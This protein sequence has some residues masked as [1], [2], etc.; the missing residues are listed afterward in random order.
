MKINRKNITCNDLY[1]WVEEGQ[2][3]L[4]DFEEALK[5]ID[6]ASDVE[7]DGI[8]FQL[9]IADEFYVSTHPNIQHYKKIQYSD[10][11]LK[12][13]I[14]YTHER[15]LD[16]IATVL[17][18][19]LIP[20]LIDFGCNAFVI[21]ASDINNPDIIDPVIESGFPFFISLPLASPEEVEWIIRKCKI[22]KAKNYVLML[23]QHTMA[24]GDHGVM[25]EDSNLGYLRTLKDIYDLP[26]GYIDHSS[27]SSMPA[28]ARASGANFIS[29]HIILNKRDKGPDWFVAQEPNELKETIKYARN[30]NYS[31][32]VKEK[33]LAPGENMDIS[34]MRRSIVASKFIPKDTVITSAMLAYKRPGIGVPP[35]QDK[36]ILGKVSTE[37][38]QKDE[39]INLKNLK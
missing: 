36:K 12:I 35:N 16:F 7:A 18:K 28:V 20:K 32:S 8:E 15:G 25:P 24:S 6:A 22:K 13:I 38:I 37:N 14:D 17:S 4:G 29:K 34:L 1:F 2:G 5:F 9:A 21:N 19:S 11:K 3:S 33:V 23:G 30:I 10:N 27:S 31:L 39:I 26:V